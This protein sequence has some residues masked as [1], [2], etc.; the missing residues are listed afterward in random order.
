MPS[1]LSSH[2][3]LCSA[4]RVWVCDYTG[5]NVILYQRN[6]KTS[7]Y[8]GAFFGFPQLVEKTGEHSAAFFFENATLDDDLMVEF[9]HFQDV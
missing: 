8:G 5:Q 9:R 2:M 4:V 1:P 7:D 6:R 3:R